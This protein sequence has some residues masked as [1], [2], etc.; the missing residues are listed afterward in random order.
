MP[1]KRHK[2]VSLNNNKGGA[3]KT[4]LTLGLA[5]SLAVKGHS[6]LVIDMDPQANAS[7]RLGVAFDPADP[8][9]TISEAIQ[10]A[11]P[12]I[13]AQVIK[14]CA[15]GGDYE[16]RIWVAPSRFD[17][18][19]RI[20]EASVTGAVRRLDT[21]LDG[22][23][24]DFDVVLVDCPP[25]LGH[26]TQLA[27]AAVGHALIAS[28]PEY[29]DVEGAVRTRDF[30]DLQAGN[31]YNPELTLLGVIVTRVRSNL[32]AHQHQL[33]GMPDTFGDSLWAPQIPER[34]V[35]KDAN[36]AAVPIRTLRGGTDVTTLIDDHALHLIQKLGI[37]A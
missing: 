13:A 35:V 20:S 29:D 8:Q 11:E 25:S 34:A 16:D 2:R 1:T 27:F 17:L 21:V 7:R 22:A 15:W 36:D 6:V 10:K 33:E 3:M 5:E 9:P 24:D 37:A 32:G 31:L 30:I 19:N 28:A 23:D 26:L 18:E 14:P 12:G 4:A